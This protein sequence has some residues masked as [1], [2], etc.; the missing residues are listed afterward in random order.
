MVVK[1]ETILWVRFQFSKNKKAF[2]E[3]LIVKGFHIF[4]IV[5]Y[6]TLPLSILHHSW[7]FKNRYGRAR[8]TIH[9][10]LG[11]GL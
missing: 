6:K 10:A 5:I 9:N 2:N 11:E 7:A 1:I 3:T 4:K 8:L